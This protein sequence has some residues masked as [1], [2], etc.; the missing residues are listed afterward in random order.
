MISTASPHTNHRA[1]HQLR[2][3]AAFAL[4]AVAVAVNAVPGT[5]GAAPRAR[6]GAPAILINAYTLKPKV[7]RTVGFNGYATYTFSAKPKRAIKS[8]SARIVGARA[9]A[10]KI[11]GKSISRNRKRF[12][13]K[14]IFPGEQGN[15]GKLVV[16]LATVGA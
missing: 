2:R 13:V 7:Q 1:S 12:T 4:A 14:L 5:A 3:P 6:P 10:V 15:P 16:R 11:T 9:H 8:A